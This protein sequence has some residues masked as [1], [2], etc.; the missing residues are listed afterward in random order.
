[1]KNQTIALNSYADYRRQIIK[2]ALIDV[3][4]LPAEKALQAVIEDLNQKIQAYARINRYEA[5]KAF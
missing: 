2:T 5:Q 3:S 1:M 4:S